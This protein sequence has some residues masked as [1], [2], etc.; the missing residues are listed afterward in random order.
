MPPKRLVAD[1]V[2]AKAQ[3]AVLLSTLQLDYKMNRE[4]VSQHLGR[5]ANY[6]AG[7]LAPGR[8]NNITLA[9]LR[10]IRALLRD[11]QT[12]RPEPVPQLG[13]QPGLPFGNTIY[14]DEDRE[15]TGQETVYPVEA[16]N[17]SI[18]EEPSAPLAPCL[19][20]EEVTY[21]IGLA[22]TTQPLRADVIASLATLLSHA[23]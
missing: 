11:K 20:A 10:G 9:T 12:P 16:L 3:I 19:T 13:T 4:K 18:V 21:L 17:P 7:L 2:K 8:D 1:N 6:L 14:I 5:S 22:A 23:K 15:W